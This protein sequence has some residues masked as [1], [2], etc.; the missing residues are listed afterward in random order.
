MRSFWR[1]SVFA[2]ALLLLMGTV[3]AIFAGNAFAVTPN[4]TAACTAPP[5]ITIQS[6]TSHGYNAVVTGTATAG[7]G[8]GCTIVYVSV[9]WGDGSVSTNTFTT[10]QANFSMSHSYGS[11]GAYH[12]QVTAFENG[13]QT[14]TSNVVFNINGPPY[15]VNVAFDTSY[16]LPGDRAVLYINVVNSTTGGLQSGY[17]TLSFYI[18]TCYSQTTNPAL[19]TPVNTI[20]TRPTA[21]NATS[22]PFTVPPDAVTGSTLSVQVEANATLPTGLFSENSSVTYLIIATPQTPSV[23]VGSTISGTNTCAPQTAQIQ[24]GQN[25][26]LSIQ[27]TLGVGFGSDPWPNAAVAVTFY[28]N[29][30]QVHPTGF[31][32]QIQTNNLGYA[33]V[34]VQTQGLG[35]GDLNITAAVTD[36]NNAAITSQHNTIFVNI[37]PTPLAQVQV[38]TGSD[39]YFGGD[40]MTSTF[41]ITSYLGKAVPGWNANEYQVLGYPSGTGCGS[42][43][44]NGQIFA[45]GAISGTSGTVPAY[46]IPTSYQGILVVVVSA[47]NATQSTVGYACALVTPPQLLIQP[48]EVTYHPG[49]TISVS[50]TPEGGIFSTATYF[51]T[52]SGSGVV[53]YNQSLQSS[54]SFSFS[55]PAT[56][57]LPSYVLTVVAQNA[58]GIIAGQ[59]ITLN[60]YSGY[61]LVVSVQTPAQYSD[62]SYQPGEKVTFSYT[63]NTLGLATPPKF[64]TLEA[65]FY[66]SPQGPTIVQET[67]SSGTF[68]LQ[69]PSNIGAG[70]VLAGFT[71]FIP[72]PSGTSGY[73]TIVGLQVNPSP[74]VLDYEL[75]AGSG[76]TV[77]HLLVIVILVI[78]ALLAYVIWRRRHRGSEPG[79]HGSRHKMFGHKDNSVEQWQQTQPEGQ[80][81]PAEHGP[82]A[83][84]APPA[85]QGQP[86]MPEGQYPAQPPQ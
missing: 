38:T 15:S 43:S 86:P 60:E 84:Y 3:L 78:A 1:P 26:I 34:V 51:A 70:M 25:F 41:A 79:A 61:N 69:V 2:V 13:G 76:F 31:P 33:Y 83:G 72:T 56:G 6:S 5:T 59:D 65:F 62:N 18:T 64:F 28:L 35:T 58:S 32:N 74:S 49:D 9:S 19:C 29:N 75:G 8:T 36:P 16:H 77:A 82:E 23:C 37:Q 80:A 46:T 12:A 11:A 52:V 14:T 45:Q 55:I 20:P 27:A 48:S 30:Q 4:V 63:V 21:L 85:D 54:T 47:N 39:G 40:S 68:T 50:F 73:G 81:P 66:N 71:A 17:T 42:F 22:I 53:I 57:T 67:A 7:A 24:P 10:A 44:S